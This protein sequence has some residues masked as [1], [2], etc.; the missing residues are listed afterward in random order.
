MQWWNKVQGEASTTYIASWIL[1][2]STAPSDSHRSH[3]CVPTAFPTPQ[4]LYP[5]AAQHATHHHTR[6]ATLPLPAGLATAKPQY[7][8]ASASPHGTGRASLEASHP[9]NPGLSML[10]AKRNK[11]ITLAQGTPPVNHTCVQFATRFV[12]GPF[13]LLGFWLRLPII[14]LQSLLVV[15]STST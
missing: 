6:P 14:P 5:R 13:P 11:P 3:P 2:E 8:R 4:R 1:K 15:C 12:S 7:R 9:V 10:G